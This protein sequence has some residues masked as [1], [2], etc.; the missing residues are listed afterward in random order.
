[1]ALDFVLSSFTNVILSEARDYEIKLL[2]FLICFF[3]LFFRNFNMSTNNFFQTVTLQNLQILFLMYL[4]Q[5]R[6]F[7]NV[8]GASQNYLMNGFANGMEI[9]ITWDH[10][11]RFDALI[12]FRLI[13]RSILRVISM[14]RS[15]VIALN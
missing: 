14:K 1:M 12:L 8:Y 5:T 15:E 6:Y 13:S 7:S 3:V 10:I 11:K 2:L 9:V 4:T